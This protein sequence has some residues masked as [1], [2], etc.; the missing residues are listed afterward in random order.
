MQDGRWSWNT[1][2]GIFQETTKVF[3]ENTLYLRKNLGIFKET[4]TKALVENYPPSIGQLFLLCDYVSDWSERQTKSKFKF[5]KI[6]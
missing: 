1:N 4:T 3:V 6:E 5:T 2:L